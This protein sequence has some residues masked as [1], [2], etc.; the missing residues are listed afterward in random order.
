MKIAMRKDTSKGRKTT[1][2]K[3][4]DLRVFRKTAVLAVVVICQDQAFSS[5]QEITGA[6][7]SDDVIGENLA[8]KIRSTYQDCV[9]RSRGVT[10]R[11][12]DCTDVELLYQDVRLNRAYKKLMTTLSKSERRDLRAEERSWL[13]KKRE[14]CFPGDEPA[15]FFLT[16]AAVCEMHEI[17]ERAT[18]LEKRVKK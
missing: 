12:H 1:G 9:D 8:K 15:G 2:G 11:V 17:A 6:Q 14:I 3:T 5:S 13:S 4:W 16:D 7:L 10:S 18:E